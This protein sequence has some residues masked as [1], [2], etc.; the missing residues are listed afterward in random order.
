MKTGIKHEAEV[1]GIVYKILDSEFMEESI[2]FFFDVFLKGNYHISGLYYNYSTIVVTI[3]IRISETISLRR[4]LFILHKAFELILPT[5][6]V[7]LWSFN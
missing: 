3:L 7:W 1:N 4:I 2:D 5:I 6:V